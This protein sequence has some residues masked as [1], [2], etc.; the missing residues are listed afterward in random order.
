[1]PGVSEDETLKVHQCIIRGLMQDKTMYYVFV[2][3]R[4]VE[5]SYAERCDEKRSASKNLS[6]K[7]PLRAFRHDGSEE[8]DEEHQERIES[9]P[10]QFTRMT[11][12]LRDLNVYTRISLPKVEKDG[13]CESIAYPGNFW[14]AHSD[15][16]AHEKQMYDWLEKVQESQLLR[17]QN[18]AE[19]LDKGTVLHTLPPI[20]VPPH[21]L[22][23]CRELSDKQ[24][25]VRRECQPQLDVDTESCIL[26]AWRWKGLLL[27][28]TLLSALNGICHELQ[29]KSIDKFDCV[30]AE[31]DSNQLVLQDYT[32]V[33]SKYAPKYIVRKRCFDIYNTIFKYNK[34]GIPVDSDPVELLKCK[35]SLKQKGAKLFSKLVRRSTSISKTEEYLVRQSG[36]VAHS[37][38]TRSRSLRFETIHENDSVSQNDWFDF[39]LHN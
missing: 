6:P 13:E 7:T 23:Q 29:S 12:P 34:H 18:E 36:C 11:W 21:M 22:S 39:L 37:I 30:G 24:C 25:A 38:E 26:Q 8:T 4:Y 9:T 14:F 3:N 2:L 10:I 32:F 16:D 19:S 31:N 5:V 28:V 17:R 35:F 33:E 20:P 27:Q 15:M 1:L